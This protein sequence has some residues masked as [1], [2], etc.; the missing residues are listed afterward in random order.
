MSTKV[1][2]PPEEIRELIY[3]LR[4]ESSQIQIQVEETERRRRKNEQ[5]ILDVQAQCPHENVRQV[6]VMDCAEMKDRTFCT[7]CGAQV[8]TRA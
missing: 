6:S 8:R 5:Q 2:L 3:P 4:Y 1:T 7:D